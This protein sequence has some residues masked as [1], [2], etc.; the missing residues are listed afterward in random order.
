ME[1]SLKTDINTF[2]RPYKISPSI[3]NLHGFF[4]IKVLANMEVA[5]S[6]FEIA[7]DPNQR[8]G[9]CFVKITSRRLRLSA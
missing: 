9:C 5:L 7:D 2:L 3:S 4:I 1:T 6:E 8:F